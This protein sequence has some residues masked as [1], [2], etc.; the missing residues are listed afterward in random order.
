MLKSTF[1]YTFILLIIGINVSYAQDDDITKEDPLLKPKIWE[2]LVDKPTDDRLWQ[3]YFGK[4]LFELSK[5]END[6]YEEWK[7]KLSAAKAK[8]EEEMRMK[9]YERKNK[10]LHKPNEFDYDVMVK[11]PIKNFGLLEDYFAREFKAFDL[12][13][14]SYDD[15][16][17]EGTYNKIAWIE[18]MEKKLKQLKDEKAAI[19]NEN[20]N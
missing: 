17:P 5:E 18:D 7:A 15:K 8:R 20:N 16:H 12:T 3:S 10:A 4:D 19:D 14:L 13:Y 1:L 6:K 11:N 2:Q 9:I